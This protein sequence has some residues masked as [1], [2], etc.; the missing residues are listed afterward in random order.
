MTSVGPTAGRRLFLYALLRNPIKAID[1]SHQGS[2]VTFRTAGS[3]PIASL[4]R[5]IQ[6]HFERRICAPFLCRTATSTK[7]AVLG[8]FKAME[9]VLYGPCKVL[10]AI[11]PS[12][13]HTIFQ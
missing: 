11:D 2:K 3:Q 4:K 8:L 7:A 12:Q 1:C 6:F 10:A 5:T 13:Y 9:V